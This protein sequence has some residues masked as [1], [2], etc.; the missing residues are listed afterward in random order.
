MYIVLYGIIRF[1][2]E[3]FRYDSYRGIISGFSTSQYISIFLIL[4]V[5]FFL[6][7]KKKQIKKTF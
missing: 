1:I 7:Y 5:L 6:L 2:L 3:F 4:S